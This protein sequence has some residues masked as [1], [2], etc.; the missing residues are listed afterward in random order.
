MCLQDAVIHF[1]MASFEWPTLHAN[2]RLRLRLR[3]MLRLKT[4]FCS[5]IAKYEIYFWL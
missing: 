1:G 5:L 3:L 2:V 4:H